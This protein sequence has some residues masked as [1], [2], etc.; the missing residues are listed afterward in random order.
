MSDGRFERLNGDMIKNKGM[1]D[2]AIISVIGAM[3]SI[4]GSIMSLRSSDGILL[5]Y[6]I[7]SD[8]EFEQG[9]VVEIMGA[10]NPDSNFIDAFVSRE[11]GPDFDL[12]LYNDF[13]TKVLHS[14]TG[15][16]RECFGTT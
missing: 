6:A 10:K 5:S 4:N 2:G 12:N 7:T 14:N 13:L 15:R 11:L 8:F 9:K 16:F 3:E 1:G